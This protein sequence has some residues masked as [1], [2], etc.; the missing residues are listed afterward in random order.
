MIN[1]FKELLQR[2]DDQTLISVIST[3]ASG[4][5]SSGQNCRDTMN[6]MENLY[7]QIMTSDQE[8]NR[9]L[10]NHTKHVKHHGF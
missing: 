5:A 2:Q 7:R 4:Y 9:D 3:I 1:S 6:F 10:N 8:L